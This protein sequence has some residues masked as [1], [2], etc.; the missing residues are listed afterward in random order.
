[1]S[2]LE[3]KL[4]QNPPVTSKANLKG[5]RKTALEE[6]KLEDSSKVKRA[7]GGELNTKNYSDRI[8]R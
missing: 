8:E 5:V 7:R 3:K 2:D 1:M 6:D 4:Q